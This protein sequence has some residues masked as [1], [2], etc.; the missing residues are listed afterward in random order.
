MIRTHIAAA[1]GAACFALFMINQ[2][3]SS[4]RS[5]QFSFL[6]RYSVLVRDG[7]SF[8]YPIF[9]NS[10]KHPCQNES[11]YLLGVGKAD[12]TGYENI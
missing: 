2:L 7:S 11:L 12:I 4:S 3:F 9:S 8:Q 5:S 1:L 10:E 6:N